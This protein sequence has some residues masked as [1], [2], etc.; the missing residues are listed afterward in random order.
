MRENINIDRYSLVV[1]IVLSFLALILLTTTAVGLPAVWLIHS[2]AERQTWARLDQGSRTTEALY[3]AWQRRISDLAFLT[4]QRPT[5]NQL[6]A[7]EQE[8]ALKNYLQTLQEDTELDLLLICDSDGRAVIQTNPAVFPDL[9]Q[10][11]NPVGLHVFSPGSSPQVWMMADHSIN[12][13]ALGLSRIIA[14]MELDNDFA[15]QMSAQ[16]NL[17][18]TLLLG[19]QP[20]ASSFTGGAA[21]CCAVTRQPIVALPAGITT[22]SAELTVGNRPYYSTH[23]SL[24]APALVDEIALDVADIAAA[25]RRLTWMLVGSIILVALVGSILGVIMAR[26]ISRPLTHLT[27]AATAISM[28]DLSTSLSVSSP[29]REVS[30]VSQTLERARIDLQ[31]TLNELQQERAWTN[32]L[33]EAITEGIVALDENGRI[34]FFSPGAERITSWSQNE[35]FNSTCD[36]LFHLSESGDSFSLHIPLPGQQSKVLLEM[37]DGHQVTLGITSALLSP[38][39]S[40]KTGLVLVLRDISKAELT[41]RLLGGFLANITHE[42][43]TPLS[44]LAASTELL[45]DQAPDL[46]P[47]ELQELLTSL[48]LGIIGLQTLIDNLLESASMETGRFRVYPRPSDLGE[49]IAEATHMT[50]PLQE[51]HGQ[52]LVVEMPATIPLVQADSRRIVQVLV[53]LLFNAIKYSPDETKITLGVVVSQEWVRITVADRGPGVPSDIKDKVF[54]QFVH[55]DM[56]NAK[57]RHGVGLGLSVVKAIIEAHNG[58]VGVDNRPG[59]GAIFWFTLPVIEEQKTA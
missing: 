27:Q 32:H 7:Q 20:V 48:Y 40:D 24:S 54:Y 16:T 12:N 36:E 28:G 19:Q 3:A 9:C 45:L 14:G 57:S 37:A 30:L 31:D 23:L 5:L 22:R 1:Q 11:Q 44:A 50:Q 43:R 2:Q 15:K 4:S 47:G 8:P 26:R 33:L 25:E 56:E 42:F 18:H 49:I 46:N 51:K 38:P 41:H 58:Q 10:L 17:E 53:N 55:Y 29:V 34:T 52:W 6:L 59:G 35:A 39:D 13:E 21:A